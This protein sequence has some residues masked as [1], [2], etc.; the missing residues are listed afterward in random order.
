MLV[1]AK[2]ARDER[3]LLEKAK[4][5][6]LVQDRD[7]RVQLA[8]ANRSTPL[9]N[10]YIIIVIY[11]IYMMIII[12][13]IIARAGAPQH[14]EHSLPPHQRSSTIVRLAVVLVA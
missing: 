2:R 8:Q 13:I 7:A 14:T 12:Y 10:I 5:E 4:A 3:G 9:Y 11:K 1:V 6:L